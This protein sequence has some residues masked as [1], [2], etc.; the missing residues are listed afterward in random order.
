MNNQLMDESK[1]M[2]RS[3]L[4]DSDFEYIHQALKNSY[5]AKLRSFEENYIAFSNSRAFILTNQQGQIFGF[6]RVITDYAIFA[7]LADVYIGDSYR[8]RGLGK[9]L[10]QHVLA[11]PMLV[12]V[13]KF[14]LKT[15]DAQELY[16]KFGFIIPE[17][18]DLIMEKFNL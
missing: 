10:I 15:N 13:K 2:I 17:K 5:W 9:R 18:H 6:A 8:G 12:N 16:A 7:Y 4:L 3:E 11:D 1:Y 14:M